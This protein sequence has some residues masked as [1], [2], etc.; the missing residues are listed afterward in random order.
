MENILKRDEVTNKYNN[1]RIVSCFDVTR[2]TNDLIGQEDNKALL[3]LVLNNKKEVIAINRCAMDSTNS[4]KVHVDYAKQIYDSCSEHNGTA[5][6]ICTNRSN[7]KN[8]PSTNDIWFTKL[9][10]ESSKI[11]QI[12]LIDYIIVT[13]KEYEYVSLSEKGFI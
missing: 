4:A 6:V 2:L 7:L 3:A 11:L 12:P 1:W 9:L 5:I 10:V 13:D 8:S